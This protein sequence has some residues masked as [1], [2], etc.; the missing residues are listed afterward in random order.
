MLA[1]RVS[2]W[3]AW[4]ALIG[5]AVAACRQVDATPM[6]AGPPQLSAG[7]EDLTEAS[8]YAQSLEQD[9]A[10]LYAACERSYTYHQASA[11]KHER[12]SKRKTR[13]LKSIAVLASV[14]GDAAMKQDPYPAEGD[15]Y[16]G[17]RSRRRPPQL[18]PRPEYAYQQKA[19][20]QTAESRL[21]AQSL[22]AS[23]MTLHD[24]V[25]E[26]GNPDDWEATERAQYRVLFEDSEQACLHR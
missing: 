6:L 21:R 24:F 5:L 15:P 23:I 7:A 16:S 13:W 17:A 18:A 26:H 11:E 4:L 1:F 8:S 22:N 9:I 10:L 25:E 2:S 12:Q 19:R 20:S 3:L 14:V